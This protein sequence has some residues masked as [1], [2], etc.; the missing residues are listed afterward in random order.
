MGA[1]TGSRKHAPSHSQSPQPTNWRHPFKSGFWESWINSDFRTALVLRGLWREVIEYRRF[2]KRAHDEFK[3]HYWSI[4]N[5][6]LRPLIVTRQDVFE[7]QHALERVLCEPQPLHTL[8]LSCCGTLT[9][10][11]QIQKRERR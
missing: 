11:T 1:R 3:R 9:P 4:C 10:R 5:R 8:L 6:V 2:G 7:S